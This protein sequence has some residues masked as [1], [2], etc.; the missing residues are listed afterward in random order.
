M[1]VLLAGIL[2]GIFSL[3]VAIADTT[4]MRTFNFDGSNI[5]Q[6]LE[7]ATE[8]TKTEY[9]TERVPSTCYRTEYRRRCHSEPGRCQQTCHPE[10]GCRTYCS[11]PRQICRNIAVQVPYGCMRDVT[12]SYEVFDYHVNS[13][14]KV[15]LSVEEEVSQI[16]ENFKV[17]VTGDKV[18]IKVDS[19]KNYAIVL[20]QKNLSER[21]NGNIKE[22]QAEYKINLI[23]A[24]RING[25]LAG[26]IQ[27]VKL[28]NNVLSFT[29]GEGFNLDDFTQR[30]RIF[31]YRRIFTD[32]LVYDQ[33][34]TSNDLIVVMQGGDSNITIDLNSLGVNVPFQKRIILDTSY[35]VGD[36]EILNKTDFKFE[37]SSNWIFR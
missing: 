30:L 1:R 11:P 8:K 23:P 19:S 15:S 4:Q 17:S 34:L 33:S 36:K 13:E 7:M 3:S 18:S 26:G 32:I 5:E 29:L 31:Q 22:I 37:A 25:V 12:R 2:A 9:R 21:W 6:V 27:N 28:N 16:S 24:Q 20:D 35:N 10:R 14:V